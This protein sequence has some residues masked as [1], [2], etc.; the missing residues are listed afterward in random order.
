M[1][2]LNSMPAYVYDIQP[3][4]WGTFQVVQLC[5][6]LPTLTDHHHNQAYMVTLLPPGS[7]GRYLQCRLAYAMLQQILFDATD[8]DDLVDFKVSTKRSSKENKFHV[9]SFA[10]QAAVIE[11]Y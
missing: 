10:L 9:E 8:F 7:R 1:K 4:V 6:I 3:D 2:S 5:H 11:V